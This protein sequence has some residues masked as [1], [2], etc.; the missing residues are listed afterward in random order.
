MRVMVARGLPRSG[1]LAPSRRVGHAGGVALP[2]RAVLTRIMAAIRAARPS[3]RS[4][5][6]GN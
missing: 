1:R 3:A 2:L 5:W 4:A 6:T